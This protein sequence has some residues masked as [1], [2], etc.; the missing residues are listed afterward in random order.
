[1]TFILGVLIGLIVGA[2]FRDKVKAIAINIWG[3]ILEKSLPK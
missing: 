1:M 3:W 2:F